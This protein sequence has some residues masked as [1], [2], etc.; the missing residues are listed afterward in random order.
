MREES[1]YGEEWKEMMRW[2]VEETLRM[3]THLQKP[4]LFEEWGVQRQVGPTK[5][6]EV[7]QFMLGL[8]AEKGI[9][10]MFNGW[11]NEKEEQSMLIYLDDSAEVEMIR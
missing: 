4:I 8:F 7:Y 3:Q 6:T 11:G 1:L 2:Y 10:N 5:R 9:S